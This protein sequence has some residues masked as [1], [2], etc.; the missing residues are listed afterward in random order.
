MNRATIQLVARII[1]R[2]IINNLTIPTGYE[3][4]NQ[5][6]TPFLRSQFSG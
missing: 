1:E 3:S 5:N 6:Q 4:E 2:L